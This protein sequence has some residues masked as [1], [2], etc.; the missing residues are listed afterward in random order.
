MAALDAMRAN[1]QINQC[2][3]GI[4]KV[5]AGSKQWGGL[6]QVS[7]KLKDPSDGS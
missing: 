5:L 3:R 4:E 7:P 1:R 2:P 6:R